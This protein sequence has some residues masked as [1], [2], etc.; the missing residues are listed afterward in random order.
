MVPN[1]PP[2]LPDALALL[3]LLGLAAA[4]LNDVALRR[5]PN[6]LAAVVALAGLA[7][8]VLVGAPAIA[9]L[10]AGCMLLGATLLWLRGVLGGGD[11]KL[12]A[13]TG[14]L[15]P[16]AAI[17]AM[18]LATALAGGM[19]AILHLALR[20]WLGGPTQPR[21]A[22]TLR[23]VLRCEAWRIRRGAP[24]PYGVA[25]AAGTAFVMTGAGV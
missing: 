13:A 10:A 9:L 16:A 4:A 25:I 3:A 11:V 5:I 7:R 21:P 15:L 22:G 1:I 19:L 18:L 2:I 20:G 17:P 12:L 23:R 14:L 8:Q 24:L 6:L